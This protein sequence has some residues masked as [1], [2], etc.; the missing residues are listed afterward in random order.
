[1]W[2]TFHLFSFLCVDC[3]HSSLCVSSIRTHDLDF[4][5]HRKLVS[6]RDFSQIPFSLP[7]LPG[8]L[9]N[10]KVNIFINIGIGIIDLGFLGRLSEV[11]ACS[12]LSVGTLGD[13]CLVPLHVLPV[14][15]L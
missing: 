13:L 4:I 3:K 2:G 7:S 10:T 1:M 6:L 12:K 5:T 15:L 9:N 8:L 11:E 14:F